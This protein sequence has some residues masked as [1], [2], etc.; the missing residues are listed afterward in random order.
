MVMIE[1]KIIEGVSAIHKWS[2]IIK[3][4]VDRLEGMSLLSYIDCDE[5]ITKAFLI[6]YE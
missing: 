1:M 4:I 2:I 3:D 5:G 6:N